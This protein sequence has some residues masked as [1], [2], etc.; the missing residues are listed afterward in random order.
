MPMIDQLVIGDV[1]SYEKYEASV[2]ERSITAPKKK[3]IRQTVPFS[4]KT[5]DFSKIDGELYWEEQGLKYVLEMIADS[6]EKLEEK[7][8]AFKSW[9][10]NVFE[11]TIQ[12][13]FI[14]GYHF[15]GT[16]DDIDF[17]D[18]GE[19]TTVTVSFTAYPYMIANKETES[20]VKVSPNATVNGMLRNNSSHRIT[21][22]ITVING[23][24]T[25]KMGN[26]SYG[27]PAG[28]TKDDSLKFDV[29]VVN[30]QITNNTNKSVQVTV[31]FNEEVF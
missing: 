8:Q 29:G 20:T 1:G 13:P 15:V 10:M 11:E 18:D 22:T 25:L 14:N 7:K 23:D 30:F 19:K 9:V 21:P 31:K 3:S 2:K 5:Y 12:D 4:N 27:I 17:A 16:F 24:I 6:A 26:A 28:T